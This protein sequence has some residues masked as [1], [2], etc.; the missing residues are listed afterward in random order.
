MA[1]KGIVDEFRTRLAIDQQVDAVTLFEGS[2]PLL[3]APRLA[4]R[5]GLD[6]SL[7]LKYEG[8]N[9]TGSFKDR[10]MT[11]AVSKAAERG[12]QAVICASTGISPAARA[13]P[14]PWPCA[15]RTAGS[16]GRPNASTVSSST[17]TCR[18]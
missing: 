1:W 10:G 14:S 16:C 2:T 4:K 5:L 13:A 18:S 3:P 9:P 6:L 15:I 8:L 12:A 11:M 7:F 17:A